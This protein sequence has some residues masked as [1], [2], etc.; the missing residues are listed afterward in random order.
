[1][2]V[3]TTEK[4]MW[5]VIA[6]Y[7]MISSLSVKK[8]VKKQSGSQRA[9]YIFCL[10]LAFSLL[11]ENHLHFAFLYEPLLPQNGYWKITG[12][13]LCAAGLAFAL[14]ARIY[15]GRN[16]SGRITIKENHELIQSGPYRIT[17]N[18]IY[19]GF[20]L[21]FT[22]CSMSL[23][24]V[25][26]Y[27]GIPLLLACLLIKISKEELYMQETFGETWRVYRNRVKCLVPGIY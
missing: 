14:T 24:L 19:S 4:L 3:L 11:F 21:A 7:W 23:G 12:M 22:G 20:L 13:V 25:K 17:R 26:G 18:P 2:N 27:L 9:V 1:M 5:F 6:V 10:L 15:L 16:W 8:S